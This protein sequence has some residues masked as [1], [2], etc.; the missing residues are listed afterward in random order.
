M[1]LGIQHLCVTCKWCDDIQHYRLFPEQTV[2]DR[3][4][5]KDSCLCK[6]P[7]TRTRA[8]MIR[9]SNRIQTYIRRCI[10]CENI[11]VFKAPRGHPVEGLFSP[12]DNCIQ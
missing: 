11:T 4:W 9:E 10:N 8:R 1:S 7:M 6:Y 3:F 2:P 12:C 5:I